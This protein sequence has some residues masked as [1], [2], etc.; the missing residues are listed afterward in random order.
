[1][2]KI[3]HV[4]GYKL[5]R[6]NSS[7]EMYN[8][9]QVAIYLCLGIIW[10]QG[11]YFVFKKQPKIKISNDALIKYNNVLNEY[12][13]NELSFK[14]NCQNNIASLLNQS[15]YGYGGKEGCVNIYY[16]FDISYEGF[17]E[18]NVENGFSIISN[19]DY[20]IKGYKKN[21]L[22]DG[23]IRIDGYSLDDNNLNSLDCIYENG[24]KNVCYF[25]DKNNNI[26]H[27]VP[28]Y[29]KIPI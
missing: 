12:Y 26:K 20:K 7:K 1:M 29:I 25:I 14:N 2:Q 10:Y 17:W 21:D 22:Y 15:V 6:K 27:V 3:E 16:T 18:N 19:K 28:D 13:Y 8:F 9:A 23:L 4:L 11:C 5:I 24:T